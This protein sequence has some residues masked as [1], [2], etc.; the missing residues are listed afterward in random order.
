MDI[1]PILLFWK[2]FWVPDFAIFIFWEKRNNIHLNILKNE[3]L[4]HEEW[5]AKIATFQ[6]ELYTEV[7]KLGGRLSGEHGIGYKR[8][9]LMAEFT[10]AAE[11]DVMRA[12]K[13]A[14]DPNLILNP[15]KIFDVEA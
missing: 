6:R 4:S 12:I 2:V 3:A 10:D 13:K 11:L 14:M 15:G 5:E 8:K 7:Y 9:G 1:G